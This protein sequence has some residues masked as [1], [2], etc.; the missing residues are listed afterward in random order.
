MSYN[1]HYSRLAL[2]DLDE[3]WEYVLTDS[4]SLDVA[5][6][7]AEN[8]LNTV[9]KLEDFPE[10]GTVLDTVMPFES[11]YRVLVAGNY[12]VFYRF[13]GT[14][15]FIDRIIHNRRN[16]VRILFGQS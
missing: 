6:N 12:L 16:Y 3:I 4:C 10:M 13:I 14:N 7:V 11:D 2:Q 9:E 5:G 15:V 1:L 8:V